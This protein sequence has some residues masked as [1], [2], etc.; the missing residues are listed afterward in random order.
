MA[1]DII[2]TGK[3]IREPAVI[4]L[5]WQKNKKTFENFQQNL[6]LQNATFQIIQS[7]FPR[8]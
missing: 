6:L 8:F 2:G 5:F 3:R 4:H 7:A 1:T